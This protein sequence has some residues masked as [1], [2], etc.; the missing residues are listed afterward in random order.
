MKIN[1]MSFY[2]S[3]WEVASILGVSEQKAYSI[4]RK[5]NYE[6]KNEG[7]EVI[8]GK[9]LKSYFME[10]YNINEKKE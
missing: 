4:I 9:V 3:A 6:L 5:L 2:F 1:D 7:Y 10:K 8:K